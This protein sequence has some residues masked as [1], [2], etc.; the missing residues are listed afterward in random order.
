MRVWLTTSVP[1]L[2]V[3]RAAESGHERLLKAAAAERLHLVR[4]E[5]A[6]ARKDLIARLEAMIEAQAQLIERL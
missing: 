2:R 6:D 5:G 3:Q 1:G 4:I